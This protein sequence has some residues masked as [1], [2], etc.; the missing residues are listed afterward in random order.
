MFLLRTSVTA[1]DGDSEYGGGGLSPLFGGSS[2]SAQLRNEYHK[3]NS[4]TTLSIFVTCLCRIQINFVNK[5][6]LQETYVSHSE[7]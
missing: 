2:F 6:I 3:Y 5:L 4:F 1:V 7:L